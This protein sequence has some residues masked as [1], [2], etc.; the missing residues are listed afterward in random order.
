MLT[1][2]SHYSLF[3]LEEVDRAKLILEHGADVNVVDHDG[4]TPL[5]DATEEG[6]FS[7]Q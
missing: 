5:H 2:L 4:N 6:D 7:H 1:N 3:T